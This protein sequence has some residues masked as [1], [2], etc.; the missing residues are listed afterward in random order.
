MGRN[1][2][3]VILLMLKNKILKIFL[4]T[5]S[6][7]VLFSCKSQYHLNNKEKSFLIKEIDEM[8]ENDQSARLYFDKLDSIYNVSKNTNMMPKSK[9]K[10]ILGLKYEKYQSSLDS[11]WNIINYLDNQN[12]EKLIFLTKRHGFPSNERLGVYKAKA[13]FIFVHSPQNYFDEINMLIESEFNEGRISE[14]QK[15]YIYW[16]TKKER[17]GSPP[18]KG[19][20]GEV[21]W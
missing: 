9:K 21:I 12:T 18:R 11:I 19:K 7:L 17:K 8:Y 5:F 1:L 4:F 16:H 14:Y 6:I 13:Y 10:E 3:N 15:E 20:N 2:K